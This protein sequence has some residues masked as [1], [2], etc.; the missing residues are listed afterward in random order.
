MSLK[1][2]IKFHQLKHRLVADIYSN[3]GNLYIEIK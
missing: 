3:L 2:T 1:I